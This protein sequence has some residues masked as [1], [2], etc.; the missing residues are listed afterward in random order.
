MKLIRLF[1]RNAIAWLLIQL[2]LSYAT[3]HIPRKLFQHQGYLFKSHTF[4]DEGRFWQRYFKVKKWKQQLP[5]SSSIFSSS[6]NH[7]KLVSTDLNT[8]QIFRTETNRAEF[9]HWLTLLICPLFYLWNPKWAARINVFYAFFSSLPFIIVQRYNRP[10]LQQLI[11]K[12]KR[13]HYVNT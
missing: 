4:E 6:F 10:K 5:D 1:I 12:Q 2:S 11:I 13:R 3:M 7:R 8:I 9:T